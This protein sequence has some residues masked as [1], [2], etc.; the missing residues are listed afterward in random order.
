MDTAASAQR[1]AFSKKL[2]DILNAG[3]LNL[4]MGIGYRTR[5]FDVMD[6]LA[7]PSSIGD[8]AAEAGLTE[9][10]VREWLGIMVCGGIVALSH[11]ESGEDLFLLPTA[12]ADLITRRAGNANLGVYTQEI[13]LLTRTALSSVLAGFTSGD[14]VD[15]ACYTEFQSFMTQLADAKHRQVLVDTFLPSVDGGRLV[16]KLASGICVCDLGC[17]EG[18]APLLMAAAFPGSR[19][20]GIDISQE[21]LEKARAAASALSLTNVEFLEVDAAELAADS[22]LA[23]SFDYVTAFDAIHDQ[24]R[25]LEALRGVLAALKPGGVFSMV[26]IDASSDLAKN[27]EHSMGPFLY[28]VSLMHCMPVGLA[29]GGAGLGMMWGRERAVTM[30]REAGFADVAVLEIPEDPFNLHFFCRKP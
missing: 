12:H 9:R 11:D 1:D 14:G 21:A 20:T 25:P 28:T 18:L 10:Y 30:L 26:D 16:E 22:P 19:F 5:L 23:D 8:I 6:E 3:A 2:I 27:V 24:T 15:Y 17:G 7:R 4:A 29:G 13:P